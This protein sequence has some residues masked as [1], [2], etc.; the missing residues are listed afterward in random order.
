M[1]WRTTFRLT[2]AS[3]RA[4]RTSR[5]A[6]FRSSSV[7]RPRLRSF[8]KTPFSRSDRL[9]NTA[10]P[11]STCQSARR[12]DHR[13]TVLAKVTVKRERQIDAQA[14]HDREADRIVVRERLVLVAKQD[15][16][17]ALLVIRTNSNDHRAAL[18]D[19]LQGTG[20]LRGCPSRKYQCMGF[21]EHNIGRVLTISLIGEPAQSHLSRPMVADRLRSGAPGRLTY[22]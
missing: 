15:L 18:R 7:T 16:P 20:W 1:N 3:R 4:I 13:P 14:L 19:I 6:T 21:D 10:A 11:S 2:S 17:C 9:S 22:R 8:S 12:S 5:S